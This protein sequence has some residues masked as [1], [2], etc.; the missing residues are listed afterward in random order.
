MPSRPTR[1]SA[2]RD[3]IRAVNQ[4]SGPFSSPQLARR[5]REVFDALTILTEAGG[6]SYEAAQ[7]IIDYFSALFNVEDE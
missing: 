5:E 6:E 4:D 7:E 1:A 3:I 2:S